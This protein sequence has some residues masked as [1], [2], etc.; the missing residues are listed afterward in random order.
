MKSERLTQLL[1]ATCAVLLAANL[2]ASQTV[3][4]RAKEPDSMARIADVLEHWRSNGV[5][6]NVN[7]KFGI[8]HPIRVEIEK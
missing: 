8:R 1:L 7:G 5:D 4:A 3:V 6:V 2:L